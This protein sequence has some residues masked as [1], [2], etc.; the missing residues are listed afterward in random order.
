MA[1]KGKVILITG[2]SNRIGAACAEYFAKEGAFALFEK[3]DERSQ[4]V[5][6]NI[7]MNGVKVETPPIIAEICIDSDSIITE[8]FVKFSRLDIIR[9]ISSFIIVFFYVFCHNH[10]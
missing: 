1:F 10:F 9:Y 4:K 6:E 7:E 8:P 5:A 3:N 2:A